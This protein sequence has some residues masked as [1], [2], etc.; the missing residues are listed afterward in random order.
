MKDSQFNLASEAFGKIAQLAEREALEKKESQLR[1]ASA[2][3]RLAAGLYYKQGLAFKR[4]EGDEDAA[5]AFKNAR[6]MVEA[7][8]ILDKKLAADADQKPF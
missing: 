7:K 2:L 6:R 8:G 4:E 3:F 1:G 5:R